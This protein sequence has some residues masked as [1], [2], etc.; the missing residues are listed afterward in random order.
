MKTL[1]KISTFAAA[2]GFVFVVGCESTRTQTS[3][4]EQ[5]D[6]TVVTAKVKAALIDDENLSASEINVETFK[7]RV[8]LSGFVSDRSDIA[9][10][11]DVV[12]DI[13][14]VASVQ[15]DLVVK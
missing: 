5:I 13:D 15:N 1:R 9:R 4:G 11:T 12:D 7:G 3:A 10:A 6:D 2:L 8:Q 14:G